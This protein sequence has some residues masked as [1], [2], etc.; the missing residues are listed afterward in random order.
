MV[1]AVLLGTLSFAALPSCGSRSDA[2]AAQPGAIAGKVVEVTG[3]VK[4][5]STPL[6]VGASVKADDVIE[7]GTDGAVVIELAHNQARWELGPNNKKKPTESLA[8]TAAKAAGSAA[9]THEQTSAAGRP[10]ERSAADGA[11]SAA[12]APAAQPTTGGPTPPPPPMPSAK[13]M[14]PSAS[15]SADIG[16]DEAREDEALQPKKKKADPLQA[17]A[18]CLPVG[19]TVAIKVHIANHVPAIEFASAVDSK[20]QA[21]ITAAAKKLSLTV[22]AG[23]LELSLTR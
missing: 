22:E 16:V 14:M 5:G 13:P 20:V 18:S 4:A 10:A 21:C 2:P 1:R 6:V 7:T 17:L 8:W 19:T 11:S 3:N 15:S 23:D 9:T 12:S